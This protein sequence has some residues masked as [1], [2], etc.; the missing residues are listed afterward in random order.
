MSGLCE[1][2][3]QTYGSLDLTSAEGIRL[4]AEGIRLELEYSVTLVDNSNSPF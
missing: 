3:Q 4:E 2:Q 1:F